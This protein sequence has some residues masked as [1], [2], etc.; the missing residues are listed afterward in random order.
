MLNIIMLNIIMLNII[1]LNII[2]LNVIMLNVI[3]LKVW[4]YLV[5]TTY[6]ELKYHQQICVLTCFLFWTHGR[7]PGMIKQIK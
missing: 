3:M 5:F 4:I 7:P 6:A 1:M 2:M